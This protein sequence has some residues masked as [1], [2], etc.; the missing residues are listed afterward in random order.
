LF[1]GRLGGRLWLHL[2]TLGMATV[3]IPPRDPGHFGRLMDPDPDAWLSQHHMMD[4]SPFVRPGP[5]GCLQAREMNI[6]IQKLPA[7]CISEN[8]MQ[9]DQQWGGAAEA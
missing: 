3:D 8:T 1:E 7:A 9:V 4:T 5:R 2:A 6:V